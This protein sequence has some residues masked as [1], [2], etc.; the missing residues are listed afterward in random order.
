MKKF[1]FFFKVFFEIEQIKLVMLLG[2]LLGNGILFVI[3][4]I[5]FFIDSLVKEGIVVLFVVKFFKVWMVEKDVNFV[6]L[7]LRKVNLD[8]RL[9]EFFLVNRQSVDY[10]VKY[11][12]D[13]GFKEFF[14]FF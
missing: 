8:K 11:F 7:F 6:I 1:F 10:F 13:V 3:I 9:F 4:F 5:S 14:D 12:I 2:I